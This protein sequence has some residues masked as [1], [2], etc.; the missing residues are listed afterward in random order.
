MAGKT[1]D[2]LH[3]YEA[4]GLPRRQIVLPEM[5]TC[6]EEE[7]EVRTVVDDK[8]STGLAAEARDIAGSFEEIAAPV[9]LVAD[10]EDPGAPIEKSG[11]CCGQ[12]EGSTGER[13]AIED[14]IDPGQSHG[15]R[16]RL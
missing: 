6:L 8:E 14:R 10:L 11:C 15:N 12:R 7:G 1:D 9:G 4:A 16:K 2:G 3:S 13:F 5:E